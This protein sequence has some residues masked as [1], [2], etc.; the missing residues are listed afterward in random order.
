MSQPGVSCAHD[1]WVLEGRS[2]DLTGM[3]RR[4]ALRR[5]FDLLG[6]PRGAL[7]WQTPHPDLGECAPLECIYPQYDWNLHDTLVDASPTAVVFRTVG[8]A[9]SR[10]SG[11]KEERAHSAPVTET[12]IARSAAPVWKCHNVDGSSSWWLALMYVQGGITQPWIR[13]YEE[14]LMCCEMCVY[15]IEIARLTTSMFPDQAHEAQKLR[16]AVEAVPPRC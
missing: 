6:A 9:D 13:L 8:L 2:I 14:H 15:H 7:W 1:P 16:A 10:A 11:T 3:A 5:V 4:L 12:T